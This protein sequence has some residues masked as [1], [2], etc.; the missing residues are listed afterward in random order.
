MSNNMLTSIPFGLNNLNRLKTLNY[1]NNKLK[2]IED[3]SIDNVEKL[4]ISRNQFDAI[5]SYLPPSLKALDFSYNS[6]ICLDSNSQLKY[7]KCLSLN[8]LSL[9]KISNDIVFDHLIELELSMNRLTEIPNLAKLAPKLKTIDLSYNFLKSF[10]VFPEEIKKVDLGHNDIRII[11]NDIKEMYKQLKIFIITHNKIKNIPILPESVIKIDL[12]HNFIEVLS[13]MNTPNLIS[14]NLE[15]NKLTMAPH[16]EGCRV[17]AINLAYNNLQTISNSN[18]IFS[19]DVTIIDIRNNLITELPS[20]IFTPNLQFLNAAGNLIEKIPEEI[21]NCPIMATLNISL[22]PLEV[23]PSTLPV[24][25]KHIY[26]GF[27][28]LKMVPLYFANLTSLLTLTVPGNQLVHIPLIPSLKYV[29]L[30]SNIF[31]RFPRVPLTI[32]SI[33]V[34][35]NKITQIPDPFNFKH[36]EELELSFN[37]ISKVP[38]LAHCTNLKILK[39][40][41]NPISETVHPS[42]VFPQKSLITLDITNTNIKFDKNPA[43]CELLGSY[44]Y[45]KF[46]KLIKTNGYVGFAEMKGVRD[47]MEDS[48]VIRTEINENRDLFG[49]FDGHGGRQTSTWLAFHIARQ[50]EQ[51]KVKLTNKGLLTSIRVLSLGL[52]QQQYIDG[53][54]AVIAIIHENAIFLMNIGDARALIISQDFHVKL[55]TQDHK[56]ST[57]EEFERVAQ[58]G[59]FVAAT[60]RRVAGRLAVPRSFGDTTTKGVTCM[61]DITNYQIESDDRWLIL[62]CDGVFDVLTNEKVALIAKMSQSAEHFAYNIRNIAYSYFSIDNISVIVVDLLKRR[63]FKIMQK[64]IRR[65]S[66]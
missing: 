9:Q 44:E 7:V 2:L 52:I 40:S 60:N 10:P 18:T 61:P 14:F 22:N 38:I 12:S 45:T 4:N 48:I 32:R 21:N 30:S 24:S 49:V 64:Q 51:T 6:L 39:L 47:T 43:R 58:N 35:R 15:Y 25:I 5:P 31:E 27:C 20:Y 23:F 29:N 1:F 41:Y 36:I 33:D 50:Y 34:S 66:K 26:A 54:T 13:S 53:S 28:M 11:P 59:G 55:A 42:T 56:P 57:R 65:Q 16:F 17:H 8:L 37:M 63:N 62:G 19:N 3:G 46:S